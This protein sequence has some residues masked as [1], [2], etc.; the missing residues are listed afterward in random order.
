[1]LH[2][3]FS[4]EVIF[5]TIRKLKLLSH[6]EKHYWVF[7]GRPW[8]S[9]HFYANIISHMA[10]RKTLLNKL[11]LISLHTNLA[12]CFLFSSF[13]WWEAT[14][15]VHFASLPS[16]SLDFHFHLFI[17]LGKAKHKDSCKHVGTT[18]TLELLRSFLVSRNQIRNIRE[19]STTDICEMTVKCSFYIVDT[20]FKHKASKTSLQ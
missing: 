14:V 6:D 3:V 20:L 7:S 16:P 12:L 1:M 18:H 15:N 17:C 8:R 13:L 5:F 9:F 19:L 10:A 2:R 11:Q 4:A